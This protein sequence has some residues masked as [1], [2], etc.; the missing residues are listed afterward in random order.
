M[1]HTHQVSCLGP[2]ESDVG[3]IVERLEPEPSEWDLPALIV[4]LPQDLSRNDRLLLFLYYRWALQVLSAFKFA[5][6]RS[7]FI[8]N[9]C[10]RLVWLRSDFSVAITGFCAASAP[11]IID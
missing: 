9:F 6:L 11:S 5:H 10:F 1:L 8:R 2:L 4:P 7:V 3:V